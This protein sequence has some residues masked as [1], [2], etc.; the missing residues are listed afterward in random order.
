MVGSPRASASVQRSLSLARRTAKAAGLGIALL[1]VCCGPGASAGT[2]KSGV[3]NAVGA[4]NEYANVLSQIGGKYVKVSSILNNPNTDPHT[5]EA[6]PTVAEKVSDAE[7][8]VQ[9]GV[10]YDSFMNDIENAAPNA[11]RIVIVV[12]HVLDLP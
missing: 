6:S 5:F 12:Q 10:G 9:N 8:I 4:E 3:I 2:A 7:L 1:L 11:K